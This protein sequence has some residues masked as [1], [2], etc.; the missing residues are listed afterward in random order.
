MP[1]ATCSHSTRPRRLP[2]EQPPEVL[3][4]KN[5]KIE[6]DVSRGAYVVS[7]SLKGTRSAGAVLHAI[8]ATR[9]TPHRPRGER[10]VAT[11]ILQHAAPV[12]SLVRPFCASRVRR[13][14]RVGV[15]E[16]HGGQSTVD[17]AVDVVGS[18]SCHSA[19]KLEPAANGRPYA[20]KSEFDP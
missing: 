7:A 12:G 11:V 8:R 20:R 14:R 17:V 4:S 16:R 2:A 1:P 15:V 10:E 3:E 6:M 19:V 9:S 5:L 18:Q 13:R